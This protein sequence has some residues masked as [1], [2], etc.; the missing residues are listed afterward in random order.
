MN[1][2]W[3]ASACPL[4]NVAF[5]QT[6]VKKL[7]ARLA[8]ERGR[9]GGVR[10]MGEIGEKKERRGRVSSVCGGVRSP[11]ISGQVGRY[12]KTA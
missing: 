6:Q 8:R 12:H 2:E 4:F 1:R 3:S 11:R 9:A 5:V 10:G 7:C